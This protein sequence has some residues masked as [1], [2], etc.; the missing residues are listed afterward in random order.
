V[1]L[2]T[3][4]WDNPFWT[5]KQHVAAE[6]AKRGYRILYVESL[7]LRRPTLVAR[8][9]RRALRRLRRALCPP[10]LVR[11]NLWVWSPLVLPA[12]GRPWMRRVNR[13]LLRGGL[14]LWSRWL[15]LSP[16]LLWT[17]NPLTTE[18]LTLSRFRTVVYHCVDE[19]KAQPGMPEEIIE[20]AEDEL[21]RR[22]DWIFTSAP[23]LAETRRLLNANTY[24]FPNVADFHHFSKARQADTR[25]PPDL[26]CIP[27]PR[28]GFVGAISGYKLNFELLRRLALS[29]PKWSIVL[30]GEV[31]EGDPWTDASELRNL[32]NLHLLGPRSYAMLPAYLKG[33]RVGL[34]PNRLNEYT[35]SMF[36]MKFFEYLAAGLQVV[37]VDLPALRSEA[38]VAMLAAS[39]EAF[40]EMVEKALAGDGPPLEARL[41]RARKH[42]YSTRM[43]AMLE[44]L[45]GDIA[46][47]RNA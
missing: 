41:E 20:K 3:A 40:S 22:A 1:L 35:A 43:D 19:L 16:Q 5:N 9:L 28:L 13:W 8:D 24:F 23:R 18:F 45:A 15:R 32:P 37:S 47:D 10:R 39:E 25:I 42:T 7:G 11:P 2:S 12:H 30:I 4:D 36:P 29:H 38:D 33:F 44:I 27:E 26:A 17:Y 21:V 6:L 34:L 46:R 31:G 14:S